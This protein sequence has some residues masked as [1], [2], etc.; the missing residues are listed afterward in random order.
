MTARLR[1]FAARKSAPDDLLRKPRSVVPDDRAR[2]LGPL[3]PLIWRK[4]LDPT[5]KTKL[6]T[7]LLS[8]GRLGSDDQLKGERVG[9]IDEIVAVPLC[10]GADAFLAVVL[11]LL[12]GPSVGLSFH[13]ISM[14]REIL[15]A[16][17]FEVFEP[18]ELV[19]LHEGEQFFAETLHH[20]VAKLHH[21]GADLH[22]VGAEQ[23]ELRGVVAALDAAEAGLGGALRRR[24]L[25]AIL[26]G[27]RH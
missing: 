11:G 1:T 4:D 26:C 16:V 25:R 2:L 5:V 13:Q 22:R 24:G 18:I 7:F 23:D 6:Y 9:L 27:R 20:R 17:A 10:I 19:L 21:A 15:H 3:D 12:R 14:R 8:Y